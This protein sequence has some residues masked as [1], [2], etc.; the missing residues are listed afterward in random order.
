MAE[1]KGYQAMHTPLVSKKST[2]YSWF[3]HSTI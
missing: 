3:K 2:T 1:G